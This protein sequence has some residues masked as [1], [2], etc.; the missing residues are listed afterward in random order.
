M[1]HHRTLSPLECGSNLIKQSRIIIIAHKTFSES[2]SV[3]DLGKLISQLDCVP[4]I[5][6][7]CFINAS[8][9]TSQVGI[10]ATGY[11]YIVAGEHHVDHASELVNYPF[12][13]KLPKFHNITIT[14]IHPPRLVIG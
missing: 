5:R 2:Q 4:S 13:E 6:L 1:H 12:M 8:Q 10:F 14:S 11:T 7:F 9:P 3:T